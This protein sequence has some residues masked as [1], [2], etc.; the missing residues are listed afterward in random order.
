MLKEL[1]G[2]ILLAYAVYDNKNDKIM[3]KIYEA[4][5]IYFYTVETMG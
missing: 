4:Q 5:G 1:Y 2:R 3:N